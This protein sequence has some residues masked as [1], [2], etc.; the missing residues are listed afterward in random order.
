M[1][2]QT[3]PQL[4]KIYYNSVFQ[5]IGILRARDKEGKKTGGKENKRNGEKD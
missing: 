4:T 2:I 3:H 1:W 5:M